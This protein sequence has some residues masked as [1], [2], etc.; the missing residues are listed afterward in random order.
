[1]LILLRQTKGSLFVTHSSLVPAGKAAVVLS[2]KTQ[3]ERFD[4]CVGLTEKCGEETHCKLFMMFKHLT[5]YLN[6]YC[7]NQCFTHFVQVC[8]DRELVQN[9]LINDSKWFHI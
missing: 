3:G 6:S 4:L 8:G 5:F 2:L 1:M 7:I 9:K